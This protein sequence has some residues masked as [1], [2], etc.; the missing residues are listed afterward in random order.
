MGKSL[1]ETNITLETNESKEWYI[2]V[3][4][5]AKDYDQNN[6]DKGLFGGTVTFETVDVGKNVKYLNSVEPGSYVKYA[7]NNGCNNT[8]TVN[9]LTSCS[10]KNANASN[11]S[12][13]YCNN[14]S[15]EFNSNGWRV[16]Y[17]EG[18]SAYLVSAGATNCMCTN[19]SG[20]MKTGECLDY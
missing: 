8:T 3:W 4:I 2:A 7:G 9:R 13:G 18:D 10:G 6:T 19:S 11:T 14:S 17:I 5:S 20:S 15:H 16:A 12:M 1:L